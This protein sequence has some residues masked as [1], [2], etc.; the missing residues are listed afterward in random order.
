VVCRR[1]WNRIG[2]TFA[3]GQSFIPCFGQW[4]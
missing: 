4:R 3:L 1:S 2:R